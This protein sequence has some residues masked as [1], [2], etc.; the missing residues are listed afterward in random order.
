MTVRFRCDDDEGSDRGRHAMTDHGLGRMCGG[1][2]VV[3]V[4]SGV[5]SLGDLSRL[6]GSA[7]SMRF[8]CAVDAMSMRCRCDADAAF[9]LL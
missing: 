2:V 4:G 5:V 8:R 9:Q 1:N 7:I 6:D 3:G